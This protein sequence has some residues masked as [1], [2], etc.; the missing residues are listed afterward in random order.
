MDI[1]IY[2]YKKKPPKGGG[3]HKKLY[4]NVIQID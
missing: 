3:Y 1:K 4:F 2:F